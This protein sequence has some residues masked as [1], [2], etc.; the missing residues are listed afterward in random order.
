MPRDSLTE[1][2]LL[3][4]RATHAEGQGPAG[5]ETRIQVCAHIDKLV[6]ALTARAKAKTVR[7]VECKNIIAIV[8][9]AGG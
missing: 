7:I 1:E 5:S 6:W 8:I 9:S 4:Y 3:R 2:I